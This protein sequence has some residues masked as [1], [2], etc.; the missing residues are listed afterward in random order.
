MGIN[1]F[2]QFTDLFIPL[3]IDKIVFNLIDLS[4]RGVIDKKKKK[5]EY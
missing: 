3:Y 5:K 1:P 4:I 2:S